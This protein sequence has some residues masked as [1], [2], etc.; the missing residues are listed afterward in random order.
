MQ[1]CDDGNETPALDQKRAVTKTAE[2]MACDSA[3]EKLNPSINTTIITA[4]IQGL[5]TKNF[6]T[7]VNVLAEVAAVSNAGFIILTE[8]HLRPAIRDAEVNI[9]N[10]VMFRADRANRRKKGGVVIYVRTD[11]AGSWEVMLTGSDRRVEYM[12]LH[13]RRL[14]LVLGG[15]YRPPSCKLDYLNNVLCNIRNAVDQIG[16]PEPTILLTG[17]FNLP[18]IRWDSMTIEGGSDSRRRQAESLMSFASD[19]NLEQVIDVPTRENNVLDLV[20]INNDQLINDLKVEDT[21][22]SDHRMILLK[23]NIILKAE[24]PI[25][26]NEI[27]PPLKKLNFYNENIKWDVINK[28]FIDTDW[29]TIFNGLSPDQIYALFYEK[30]LAT[31]EKHVP[32]RKENA[33]NKRGIPRDRRILMRQRSRVTKKIRVARSDST[34]D[35]LKRKVVELE[36]KLRESHREERRRDEERAVS[37]IKTN[38]KYFYKYARSKAVI[39]ADVGP[40]KGEHEDISDPH[41]KGEILMEQYKS[42]FSTPIATENIDVEEQPIAEI[43]DNIDFNSGDI[44]KSIAD[45]NT[46][47]AP[48][49]DEIPTIFLKRCAE[50]VKRPLLLLWKASLTSGQIPAELKRGLITPIYKG[51][52]RGSPQNYRPVTLTSHIIKC[53]EKIIVSRLVEHLERCNLFN[54]AQHGFRK[55]R[56]CLSQLLQHFHQVIEALANGV[57]VDV[58]YLDFAKAF[59]K[60]DH[61][62]L[63]RKLI[64][65]GVG[66]PLLAWIECFLRHRRQAVVVE[67]AT[68]TECEVISGVPQGSVLGPLL[69]LIHIWDIDAETRFSTVSSFADDTRVLMT[70]KFDDDC[71]RLQ[72]DL[73]TIYR[74]TETNNMKLNGSKFERIRYTTVKTLNDK[75]YTAHD[76]SVIERSSQLLDLGVVIQDSATFEAQIK[77]MVAKARRQMG[78]VLRTFA[79]REPMAMLTLYKS[80]VLPLLEYASQ[81]WS[82]GAIGLIRTIEGVQRTYTSRIAGLSHLNYWQRLK[83]LKLYSLERRR[84]RYAILYIYKIF[85]RIVPNI[86]VQGSEINFYEHRRLGR[87]CRIPPFTKRAQVRVSTIHEQSFAVHAPKLFNVL[88]IDVRNFNGSVESFKNK[89]DSY[90]Q[91]VSDQP[92]LPH[93]YEVA[94]SNSLTSQYRL[95]R[96]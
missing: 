22:M 1:V 64:R 90:L 7:K 19:L 17:D 58:V 20:F 9:K 48:G 74:R 30:I 84:D 10:Y 72:E 46:S 89:L 37:V 25:T 52:D 78:W 82:P 56:S 33:A 87:H 35:R 93:Y 49:P 68:S 60:V 81:L 94:Q 42:V 15:I 85:K 23:T 57:S 76:G 34:R 44:L 63:L 47:S 13:N 55:G 69:S 6:K 5:Y 73:A 11:L 32:K 28:D 51:G 70:V 18:I 36:E 12:V 95:V 59:D 96:R 26:G 14:N 3:Q 75:N 71:A 45:F 88:P 31:C 65:I 62:V 4:N 83:T 39:K 92:V 24:T 66:G 29:D 67:G 16:T 21:I 2:E 54:D 27:R 77:S 61:G 79:T 80:T 40:F 43:L 91:T 41:R 86:K 50:G 38:P 53:F 8:S